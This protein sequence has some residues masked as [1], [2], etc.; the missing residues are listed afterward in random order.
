M[1]KNTSMK[2]KVLITGGAG[3]I[4]SHLAEILLEKGGQVTI[5]DNLST[6]SMDNITHLLHRSSFHYVID[7]I[8]NE[9]L[10]SWLIKECDEIYH[11]AAAVGVKLIVDKPIEVIFTNIIGTEIVL[12]LTNKYN[13]KVLI[14]STSEI[15]GKNENVPYQED[16]DRILGPTTKSRWT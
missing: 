16:S 10:M 1:K 5:V 7:S 2:R 3:F 6:G 15:Y 13:K 14:T 4:G 9:G 11:L 12:R 8:M